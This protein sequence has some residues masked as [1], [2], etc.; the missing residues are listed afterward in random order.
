MPP[1]GRLHGNCAASITGRRPS[2]SAL[3][4]RLSRSKRP[5]R[6][7]TEEEMRIIPDKTRAIHH[8]RAADPRAQ[9]ARRPQQP[10]VGAGPRSVGL[11][12]FLLLLSLLTGAISHGY[13]LFLYPLYIT[14]EGI[15]MQQAWSVL[16]EGQLSPYTY[17][18]D[19]AP[20]GWLIIAG[21]VSILPHQFEAF[22]NAI[23]TRPVLILLV[24]IASTFL[25]VQV[26]YRI[27]NSTV[28]AVISTFFF[29]VSP[30]AV[31]YQRQV[32]LANLMV[33]WV[34]LCLYLVTRD[35]H[36]VLIPLFRVLP[37]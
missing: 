34:L 6:P 19:H 33:F 10:A 1:C 25:L 30:L 22:G 17:F 32:L 11:E 8:P 26:T 37:L 20:A 24:H 35:R 14:D 31:F 28:A 5:R 18:Y 15:Y 2:I 36:Q 13:H 29:N 23:N 12:R 7:H 27:S 4:G 21:W 16:R 9:Q 3:T